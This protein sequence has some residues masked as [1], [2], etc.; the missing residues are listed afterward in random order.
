MAKKD[1][2]KCITFIDKI[3]TES[4]LIHSE[5]NHKIYC[6]LQKFK[7]EEQQDETEEIPSVED[8]ESNALFT[9]DNKPIELIIVGVMIF[10]NELYHVYKT[11][12]S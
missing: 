8:E 5:Q 10:L 9:L 3:D 11:G 6:D 1:E 12:T 7:K 2:K 4:C